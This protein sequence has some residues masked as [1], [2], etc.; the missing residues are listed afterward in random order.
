MQPRQTVFDFAV[1]VGGL[2][3]A[4]GLVCGGQERGKLPVLTQAEQINRLTVEQAAV[5]Y[6]VDIHGVVTYADVKLGHI[7]IQDRVCLLQSDGQRTRLGTG[8][9]YRDHGH[10]HAWRF[11]S[12]R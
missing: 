2:F 7:F 10:H 5:G 12:L 3:V 11:F 4:S 6:P 1:V 9:N 8:T